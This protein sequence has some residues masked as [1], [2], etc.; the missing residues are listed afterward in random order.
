MIRAYP[1]IYLNKAMINMGDA[2]DFAIGDLGLDGE[3]FVSMMSHSK[4]A[5]RIENGE[6][7]YL[8]GMSG[9]DLAAEIIAEVT[10]IAP[11]IEECESY[12]RTPDHWCGWSICYYQ[13]LS[14][15]PYGEIFEKLTYGDLL[16][17]YKTLHEADVTRFAEVVGR[18]FDDE[19]G[20]SGL[21]KIR[22]A[23]GYSQSR[24]AAESGVSLRSIQMY[25]QGNK[26]I[27]KA[28]AATLLRLTKAM[29]CRIEDLIEAS[30]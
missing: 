18:R 4:V 29:G 15:R 27:N 8:V 9:I 26:D 1:E 24:L 5:R 12:I 6:A 14:N 21:R 13:W 20:A 7:R 11:V 17:L 28:Q 30:M 23:Y 16:S 2:F 3:D 25:E 10:G 19:L 22:K